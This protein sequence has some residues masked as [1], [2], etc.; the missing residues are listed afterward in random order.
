MADFTTADPGTPGGVEGLEVGL[1]VCDGVADPDDC[2]PVPDDGDDEVDEPA[3][4]SAG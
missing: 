2:V 1:P 3:G 4:G